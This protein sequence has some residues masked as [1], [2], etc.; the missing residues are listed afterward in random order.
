MPIGLITYTDTG[1]RM[2]DVV[3]LVTNID[4]TSTPFLSSLG[5]GTASNT[6]H[7]WQTDT[8]TA[9]AANIGI[10]GADVTVADI[11]GPTRVNNVVQMFQKTVTVSDT[12]MALPHY[13]I[14]NPMSYQ[15]NKRLKELARDIEKA[16]ILGTRASGASGVGRSMNGAIA[17]ITTNKTARASGTSFSEDEFNA[18]IAGVFDNGTDSAADLVLCGSYLK[19]VVDKWTTNVTRNIDASEKR[20][21][22]ST[23]FYESSFGIHEF[24]ISREVPSAA[25]TAGVLAVDTSK[26][27]VDYLT[28]RRIQATPLAKTGS[29]TKVLIEGELTLV[30]LN[31]KSSAYRGGYFVG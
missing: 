20:Q 19:R 27:R 16:L 25:G 1:S 10:E 12:E 26:W 24:R 4:F 18:M 3:D 6:L 23:T 5:E 2:E 14:N 30:G 15:T 17:Q 9:A 7:E 11:A 31:E 13:G 8:L 28:G 22:L 29:A 21:I